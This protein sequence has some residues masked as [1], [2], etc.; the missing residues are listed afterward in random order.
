M[1]FKESCSCGATYEGPTDQRDVLDVFRV[2]HEGCRPPRPG[3][4]LDPE[5]PVITEAVLSVLESGGMVPPPPGAFLAED[6]PLAR[7]SK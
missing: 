6:G 3:V 7:M 4:G 2:L 5:A 1:V